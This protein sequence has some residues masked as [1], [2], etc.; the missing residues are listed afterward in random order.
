MQRRREGERVWK[1][2]MG[3]TRAE[4]S[5]LEELSA[6]EQLSQGVMLPWSRLL[7]PAA[8]ALHGRTVA[9]CSAGGRQAEEAQRAATAGR[10]R[11][12]G[13]GWHKGG[14]GPRSAA[15]H[16]QQGPGQSGR[17]GEAAGIPGSR[18]T[19]ASTCSAMYPFGT[20]CH[21]P[22]RKEKH[23]I[24]TSQCGGCSS[25]PSRSSTM[26]E[27]YLHSQGGRGGAGAGPF[28][29]RAARSWRQTN[30]RHTD[31]QPP[32][33]RSALCIA[34][35]AARNPRQEPTH[36][37]ARGRPPASS[38][39]RAH[40]A[41]GAGSSKNSTQ[42]R[43]RCKYSETSDK[44]W[45]NELKT[46]PGKAQKRGEKVCA[47][48]HRARKRLPAGHLLLAE[49][50]H[51]LSQLLCALSVA[52]PKGRPAGGREG[53]AAQVAVATHTHSMSNSI[54]KVCWQSNRWS[55]RRSRPR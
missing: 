1:E 41:A 52:L 5:H 33:L 50:P 15:Q 31:G 36:R 25:R 26:G 35:R 48:L 20:R 38:S 46:L 44:K 14:T 29:R 51:A 13:A 24:P 45:G 3:V 8:P 22:L 2:G 32:L 37:P 6:R 30:R 34:Q 18:R 10:G 28:M 11:C 27:I 17:R 19:S 55:F 39:S 4:L 53:R 12:G 16:A 9:R 47:P 21:V 42:H 54:V 40:P 7:A 49:P 23:L 43:M